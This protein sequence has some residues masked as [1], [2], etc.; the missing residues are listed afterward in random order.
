M[1]ESVKNITITNR[2]HHKA[3]EVQSIFDVDV[4]GF[5]H[6]N[7]AAVESD[8]IISATSAPIWYLNLKR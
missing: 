1:K 5:E 8:V 7:T 4:I 6:K 2:T 3:L